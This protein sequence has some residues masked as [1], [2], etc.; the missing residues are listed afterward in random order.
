MN[1]LLH[2]GIK[3]T[4]DVLKALIISGV[5][6]QSALAL[7]RFPKFIRI[8]DSQ[9][10]E[11]L[12]VNKASNLKINRLDYLR[13]IEPAYCGILCNGNDKKGS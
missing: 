1:L 6:S 10:K 11:K 4:R 5:K 2:F 7:I 3:D 8:L 13:G 12:M 9:V